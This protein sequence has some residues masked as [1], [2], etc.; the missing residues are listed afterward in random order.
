MSWLPA[1]S[2]HL[3]DARW[4]HPPFRDALRARKI[5]EMQAS[6]TGRPEDKAPPPR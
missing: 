5:I 2:H 3:R 6:P 4:L 1:Y